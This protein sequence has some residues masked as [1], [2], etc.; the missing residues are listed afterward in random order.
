MR[1]HRLSLTAFGP[2]A[3]TDDHFARALKAVGS[4]V[5]LQRLLDGA[6]KFAVH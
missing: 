4:L 1:L 3:D 2:F 6:G 5:L